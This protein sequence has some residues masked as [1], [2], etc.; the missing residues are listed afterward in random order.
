MQA[1]LR[2]LSRR[3]LTRSVR[4]RPLDGPAD[5]IFRGGPIMTMSEAMPRAEALAI[6]GERILATGRMQDVEARRGP[7]THIVN[8][9]GRTLLPGLIDHTCISFLLN[10]TIGLTSVRSSRRP[11]K[12]CKRS[13]ERL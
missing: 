11:T 8:L 9:D 10:W 13:C 6:R 12:R 1:R 3:A 2:H 5:V 7:G 4:A